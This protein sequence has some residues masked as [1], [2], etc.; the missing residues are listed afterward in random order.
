[1][2]TPVGAV[3]GSN[4]QKGVKRSA[5]G[6]PVG[7]PKQLPVFRGRV[8]DAGGPIK[9]PKLRNG[10]VNN[11]TSNVRI[12]YSRVCPLEMLTSY[13]GRLGPG[14]VIFTHKYPPG[15]LSKRP[16][17]NNMTLGVNTLSRVVGLDGLNRM[18]MQSGSNKWRVGENVLVVDES[19]GGAWNVLNADGTFALSV[20]REYSLDG[21]V[22]SNDEPGS[23]TSSGAR[24]NVLFNVAIQGP[25]ETNNG[26]LKYESDINPDVRKDGLYNPLTGVINT[27]NVEAHA[28]GSSESGMHIESTPLPGQIGN[29]QAI[30]Q[31]KVDFVANYCGTYSAFPSQMFDRRVE[32]LNTLYLGLRA[33]ELSFEA[34]KQLTKND[35]TLHFAQMSDATINQTRCFFYQY[36]PF[37]SR[38]A[39][40]IQEVT[41]QHVEELLPDLTTLTRGITPAARK[42]L[43]DATQQKDPDGRTK[44]AESV[45]STKQQTATSMPSAK[46]DTA[47]YDPIRSKDLWNMIGAW[48]VGRVMDTKAAVHD[49]YAGGP[50]DTAF[51]CIVDVQ[52]AWRTA[53]LSGGDEGTSFKAG[54]LLP[55]SER[56]GHQSESCLANNHAPPLKSVIGSDFGKN[57]SQPTTPAQKTVS[58][59]QK[60]VRRRAAN[61]KNLTPGTEMLNVKEQSAELINLIQN[62][63]PDLIPLLG[64]PKQYRSVSSM[65]YIRD[66]IFSRMDDVHN[67]V[68]GMSDE[69]VKAFAAWQEAKN[70]A[71]ANAKVR[72][73]MVQERS[74]KYMEKA[75]KEITRTLEIAIERYGDLKEQRLKELEEVVSPI[76][77]DMFGFIKDANEIIEHEVVQEAVVRAEQYNAFFTQIHLIVGGFQTVA[78]N[79]KTTSLG[80][81]ESYADISA[82][83]AAI[84]ATYEE[85]F[86]EHLRQ[87]PFAIE[88]QPIAAHG[89]AAAAP[90]ARAREAPAPARA[91]VP[92]P[93]PTSSPVAPLPAVPAATAAA[94]PVSK[95][96]RGKSPARPRPG[97]ATGAAA[98]SAASASTTAPVPALAPEPLPA[99]AAGMSSTPLVPTS[100]PIAGVTAADAAAP[101]RRARETATT[102]TSITN[103]LFEN[104]FK[105]TPK[106]A[107]DEEP[108]SPTPSSG[109]EGA[110]TGP[111]TFRRQR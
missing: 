59:V 5:L 85:H 81:G 89:G 58:M 109:S 55:E 36:L 62:N 66:K 25:V 101:R 56:A 70:T 34:K 7:V 57:V 31:G 75:T 53:D 12:P 79:R 15:F 60:K 92:T 69:T 73:R 96:K 24:D 26:Y 41:E 16:E 32:I 65:T 87:D 17:A 48:Q 99:A 82:H 72:K 45:K 78:L 38:A 43:I 84:C 50:R 47:T 91:S 51:S 10:N 77:Q 88:E 102:S 20:L 30:N 107:A 100:T 21:V 1:M 18:L 74:G 103:S 9:A 29:Q 42:M 93:V 8:V 94:A 95:P 71:Y 28:R 80:L 11:S 98:A 67:E 4:P 105:S 14:D 52:V 90:V 3:Q 54:F 23:F 40:V 111:R 13:Q 76:E 86:P 19:D 35:N 83:V 27:R 44:A 68:K 46:F 49:R 97:A 63:H 106:E 39:A 61:M 104:M 2:S 108:A 110:S 64:N 22:I 37:S 33:Y 6:N